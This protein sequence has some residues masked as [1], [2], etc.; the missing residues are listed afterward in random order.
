[1]S[2]RGLPMPIFPDRQFKPSPAGSSHDG[3]L[4]FIQYAY[5][6]NRLEFCGTEDHG[7]LYDYWQARQTD[8]GLNQLLLAFTGALPYLKLIAHSNGRADPFDR[9]VVE[10]YWVGNE[11]LD[12]VEMRHFFQALTERF[13]KQLQGK[14]REY[15]LRK[16]PAGARPH[17][18]FHVFDVH[19][20]IG[21]LAHT[22]EVMEN[23]RISWGQITTVEPAHF[24]INAQPLIL[25]NGK[26][27]LGNAVARRVLR[28]INDKGFTQGAQI[29][30]WI[31]VH[32]NWACDVLSIQQVQ[33]L[34][35]YTKQHIQLANL[36]I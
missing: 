6:P 17:H 14:M 28:Q 2:M 5:M 9:Q 7:A 18:S 27:C 36:T 26:L 32:W 30:D 13:D 15:I 34:E 3:M 24:L 1:M 31:S 23:C 8:P 33:R 35:Q 29:G 12:N 20:Q 21:E 10:A 11:L 4:L 22:L 16:I 25:H 19:S